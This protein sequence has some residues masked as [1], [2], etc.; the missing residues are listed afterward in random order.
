MTDTTQQLKIL[1]E[2]GL[3]REEN[4]KW[5][6]SYRNVIII[7]GKRYQFIANK[8]NNI[9]KNK[10]Y[11]SYIATVGSPLNQKVNRAIKDKLL[12]AKYF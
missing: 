2:N 8:F 9:S 5:G 10:I 6:R 11:Q 12:Y 3:A 1:K 7:G 4:I